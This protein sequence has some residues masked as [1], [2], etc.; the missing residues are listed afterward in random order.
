MY[1]DG[2]LHEKAVT[3][4]SSVAWEARES[5]FSVTGE[6]G[7]KLLVRLHVGGWVPFEATTEGDDVIH[8]SMQFGRLGTFAGGEYGARTPD[9]VPTLPTPGSPP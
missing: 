7:V 6:S 5:R 4:P 2:T 1:F 3:I 8:G 9:Q